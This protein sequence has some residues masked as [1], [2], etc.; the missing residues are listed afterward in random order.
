[1]RQ[2]SAIVNKGQDETKK[3]NLFQKGYKTLMLQVMK[4][5]WNNVTWEIFP[6]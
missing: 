5:P 2:Y 4:Q 3:Q 1:M 6:L